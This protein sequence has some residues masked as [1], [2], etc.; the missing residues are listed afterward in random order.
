VG[1]HRGRGRLAARGERSAGEI[2]EERGALAGRPTC[3]RTRA[4]TLPV[5]AA[6]AEPSPVP[7]PHEEQSPAGCCFPATSS[8]PL[9]SRRRAA[10]PLP[11]LFPT[12]AG[13]DA[14]EQVFPPPPLVLHRAGA[15]PEPPPVFLFPRA[16]AEPEPPPP[17]FLFPRAGT[18]PPQ[19]R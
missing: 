12:H 2:R 1:K 11:S 16:G 3:S 19:A 8:G 10:S 6:A 7:H 4:P 13:A 15:G 9:S 17:V 18:G 14:D 5:E